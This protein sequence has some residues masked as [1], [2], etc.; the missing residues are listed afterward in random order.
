MKLVYTLNLAKLF[1][2]K[3]KALHFTLVNTI[4]NIKR[5]EILHQL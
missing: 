2:K 3:Q 1:F 4:T 5:R